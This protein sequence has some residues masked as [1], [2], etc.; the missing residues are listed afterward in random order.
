M[1]LLYKECVGMWS[2][3]HLP[4]SVGQICY[5][6]D[7]RTCIVRCFASDFRAN[8]PIYRRENDFYTTYDSTLKSGLNLN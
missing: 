7:N 6:V 1:P 3:M 2:E 4:K 5:K 8:I